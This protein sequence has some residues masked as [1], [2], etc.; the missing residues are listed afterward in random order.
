MENVK[1]NV[2]VLNRYKKIQIT[3]GISQNEKKLHYLQ[4]LPPY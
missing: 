1:E 2:T 4:Q 3:G